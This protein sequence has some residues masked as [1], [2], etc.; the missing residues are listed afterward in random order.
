MKVIL[1]GATGMIGQGAL[2]ECLLA[3]DVTEVL[4]VVRKLT[5]IVNAKLRELIHA[6]FADY[7]AV[8]DKLVGYDACFFCLGT[9]SAG[10]SEPDYRRITYDYT[11]AAAHA[12]VPR[13]P[14][15]TFVYISGE[16]ADSTEKGRI[17]W[18]RVRGKT[19]NDLLALPS[20]KVYILR[21]AV[22]QPLDGI[23]ARQRW[24]R[25]LYKVTAPLLPVLKAVA[26]KYVTDTGRLG[27]AVLELA[28]H[29]AP[30]RILYTPDINA[31]GS[32]H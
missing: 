32:A 17:M 29:G 4:A 27:R 2:R 10:M 12:I 28:R 1:F 7:A 21:P 24:T 25:L 6:D 16:G 14:S 30:K 3:P 19:E 23:E 5:G 9:S 8:A 18:A 11:L 26:P 22:I 31:L 15:L 13:N 20:E